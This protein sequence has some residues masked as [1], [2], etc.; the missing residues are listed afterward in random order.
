MTDRDF[1]EFDKAAIRARLL[2]WYDRH[3][4]VLPW[5]VGPAERKA[6]VR[7]D[8][9]VVWLSEIMLQQT[10]VATVAPRFARFLERWPNVDAMARASVEDV[11][12]EWAGLGYYARARNLH[13]CAVVIAQGFAGAFPAS[14][15]EL[16][17]L[18]GVGAYTSAAVAAIAFDAPAVVVDGNVERVAARLFAITAPPPAL[19]PLAADAAALIWPR[20][21]SGDFAQAL[22]DLGAGPCRPKAPQCPA[23]PLKDVCVGY[24]LGIAADLPTRAPK[25]E[26]PS[27]RGVA[28][29]HFDA[30]GRIWLQR[31]P[32]GGLLGGTLALPGPPWTDKEQPAGAP[33]GALAGRIAHVFTHFRL[34][35]DVY[36]VEEKPPVQGQ[37]ADPKTVRVPTVMRKAID[38]ALSYREALV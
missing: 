18:P 30:Q 2:R 10:T 24:K 25:K 12:E 13:K 3:A 32:E 9:Y 15:E 31:R 16:R 26:K 19:K 5:R 33:P 1:P 29:A 8:P 20:K 37:W 36:C 28:Y 4:R 35:L 17:A 14:V 22:M 6:G 11:L 21:R 27:R 38:A 34:A 7:P 23:C